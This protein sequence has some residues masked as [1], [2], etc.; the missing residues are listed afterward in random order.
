MN[1]FK[2]WIH[3][4]YI[5]RKKN[6]FDG[7]FR[8]L[9]FRILISN[10]DL[11]N[12]IKSKMTFINVPNHL[13]MRANEGPTPFPVTGYSLFN[14]VSNQFTSIDGMGRFHQETSFFPH[15]QDQI[16][17]RCGGRSMD[18]TSTQHLYMENF[19]VCGTN[20]DSRWWSTSSRW[21]IN[22]LIT[23]LTV[24]L[25][26]QNFYWSVRWSRLLDVTDSVVDEC[27]CFFSIANQY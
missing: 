11:S 18:Q 6:I 25:D 24:N 2:Q 7:S 3:I 10:I 27:V 21:H 20:K 14:S 22:Q 15:H 1:S 13:P 23:I 9:P 19:V 12:R 4:K 26:V 16:C 8:F 17:Y 5:P